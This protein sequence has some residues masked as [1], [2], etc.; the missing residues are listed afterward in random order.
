[1][2]KEI[3][4][5]WNQPTPMASGYGCPYT[6][7]ETETKCSHKKKDKIPFWRKLKI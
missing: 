7:Y 1:M 6:R 4:E 2:I 5:N 3:I